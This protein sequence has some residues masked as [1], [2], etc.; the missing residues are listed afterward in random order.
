MTPPREAFEITTLDQTDRTTAPPPRCL[1]TLAV[2]AI[3]TQ[4][5][6]LASAFLLPLVSEYGFIGDNIS[7]LVLGRYGVVQ[8]AAFVLAGLGTL[9]L[10]VA[11]RALTAGSRGSLV[12]LLLVTVYG[13]GAILAAI[14]PTDRIDR[15]ADVG[16]QS[17]TGLIHIS[18]GLV[19]FLAVVV[20]MFVL[21]WTFARAVQWRSLA[22]WSGLCASG[23]LALLFAQS[24]GPWVGLMQRLLVAAIAAWTTAVAARVRSIAA[25]T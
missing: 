17:T 19:S 10:A 18:V 8:T 6:F 1:S 3:G 23:A 13:L 20:G 12:G 16:A 15:P 4:V 9:G 24:E 21:T 5:G 11:I 7:E 22:L 14:F 2:L 25:A